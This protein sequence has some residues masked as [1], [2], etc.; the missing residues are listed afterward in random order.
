MLIDIEAISNYIS[1]NEPL[2]KH[3]TFK[4]GGSADIFVSPPPPLLSF[5]AEKIIPYAT[6]NGIPLFILGGGSN[7]VFSDSGFKGIVLASTLSNNESTLVMPPQNINLPP[8][9]VTQNGECLTFASAVPSDTAARKAQELALCGLEFMCGL[10]GTIGGAVRMNARCFDTSVSDRIVRVQILDEKLQKVW[11]PF[12]SADWD[13]KKSPFQKDNILILQ[14]E[15]KLEKGNKETIQN[16]MNGFLAERE[17]RGHFRFPS[18]GSVFKNNREHGKPAGKIIEDL[19]LRGTQIGGAQIAPW[20]GNFIINTG[21]A[22][23]ADIAALVQIV[24]RQALQK[25]GLIL[26]T[27][28]VFAPGNTSVA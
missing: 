6:Q 4:V 17:C 18:A 10:P 15:F 26:E 1:Y 16:K 7:V 2:S 13:Y 24:Q 27:E 12:T 20:H 19:G 9:C 23:A 5:A 14:A 8:D 11:V 28:I 3:T 25:M 22:R 21:S